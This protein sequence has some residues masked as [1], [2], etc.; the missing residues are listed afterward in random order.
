TP[1]GRP[2]DMPD[3]DHFFLVLARQL[4]LRIAQMHRA[5]AEQTGEDP[6]F[7]PEPITPQDTAEWRRELELA[8]AGML[9]GLG[10]ARAGMQEGVRELADAVLGARQQLSD[11]IRVLAPDEIAAVK[12][13]YH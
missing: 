6:A 3:P 9:A 12:T 7:A 11:C 10:H 5:L 4:G 1:P 2:A 13:R 8:A